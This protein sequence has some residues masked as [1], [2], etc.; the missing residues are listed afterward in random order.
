MIV[1]LQLASKCPSSAKSAAVTAS[2]LLAAW[3]A[4][5]SCKEVT[6]SAAVGTHV[7]AVAARISLVMPLGELPKE[8][9]LFSAA[10]TPREQTRNFV[11]VEGSS[12]GFPT[13][14][15]NSSGSLHRP[16]RSMDV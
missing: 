1:V 12:T 8:R 11:G 2:I 16:S 3:P 6:D 15:S 13:A 4:V 5:E 9:V 7:L 10:P 14:K